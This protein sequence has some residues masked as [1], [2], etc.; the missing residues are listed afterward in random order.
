[1]KPQTALAI[2]TYVDAARPREVGRRLPEAIASLEATSYAD[3]VLIVDDGSTCEAHLAYLRDLARQGRYRVIR[4]ATNGGIS[5]AKNTCLRALLTSGAEVGFLAEDDILFAEGWA[6]AYTQ[7]MQ[8]SRIQHFSWYTPDDA[9]RVVV[10]NEA[11]VTATAGLL[12]L[13][14][15]FTRE[16]IATVGGFK[17]LPHRYGFEHVH[18]TQRVVSAGLAPFWVDIADSSRYVQRNS[19]PPSLDEKDVQDGTEANRGPGCEIGR[20]YEP[21]EE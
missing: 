9:N 5:R 13:L 16:V 7:A 11:L 4:R 15:T 10:C 17:I 18:W 19:R 1:M 21:L 3:P 14:M 2:L 12:G 6:D 20:I 8:R